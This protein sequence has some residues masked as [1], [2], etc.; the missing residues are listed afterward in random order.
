MEA[1]RGEEV[2]LLLIR[3]SALDGC[4]WS[5][6][7]LGRALHPGKGTPVPIGQETGWAAESDWTQRVEEKL[8]ASAGDRTWIAPPSSP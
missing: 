7:R 6:S 3:I 1:Q 8:F 2:Y 5:A 4:E